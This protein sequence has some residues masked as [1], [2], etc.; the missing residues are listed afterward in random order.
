MCFYV[1]VITML[2][3]FLSAYKRYSAS[4]LF[5]VTTVVDLLTMNCMN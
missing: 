1:Y 2:F 5:S 4:N 3:G